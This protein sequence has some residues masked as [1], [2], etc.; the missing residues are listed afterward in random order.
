MYSPGF[1][2]FLYLNPF[3]VV[4]RHI[5]LLYCS[6]RVELIVTEIFNVKKI[7]ISDI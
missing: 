4:I 3:L 1:I 5:L 6:F 2:A 7:A